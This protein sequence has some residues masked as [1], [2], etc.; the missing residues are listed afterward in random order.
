M[1]DDEIIAVVQA[2]K[3][4]KKIECR[5]ILPSGWNKWSSVNWP[6]VWNFEKAEYRVAPEPRKPREWWVCNAPHGNWSVVEHDCPHKCCATQHIKV[7]EIIE[8]RE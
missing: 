3:D 5:S 8:C 4:G 7:R 1:S 2:R 6:P